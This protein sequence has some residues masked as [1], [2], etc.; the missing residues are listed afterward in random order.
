[1]NW[2]LEG[3]RQHAELGNL[4]ACEAVELHKK[5]MRRDADVFASWFKENCREC[6]SSKVQSSAAYISY[7]GY[8]KKIGRFMMGMPAFKSRMAREG[9][10]HKSTKLF[11][12]Y[13]GFELKEASR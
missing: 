3:A 6:A 10:Q 7:V 4:S 13:V 8:A 2:A 1:L 12:A 5:R 9:Y 11:N